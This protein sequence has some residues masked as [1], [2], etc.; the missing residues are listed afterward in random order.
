MLWN[1]LLCSA[2]GIQY[3]AKMNKI[4]A[5]TKNGCQK[6]RPTNNHEYERGTVF[7][8][9]GITETMHSLKKFTI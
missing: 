9:Q 3:S 4:L 6:V 8:I 2:L 1:L 7:V 5:V